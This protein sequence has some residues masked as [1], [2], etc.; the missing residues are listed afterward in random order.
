VI[1]AP[2]H[3]YL[4]PDGSADAGERRVR[5]VAKDHPDAMRGHA[6][7]GARHFSSRCRAM[8]RRCPCWR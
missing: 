2:L 5:V 3:K 8:P 1:D 7:E 4:L 6:G